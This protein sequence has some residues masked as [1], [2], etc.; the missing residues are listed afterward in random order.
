MPTPI[1]HLH[2]NPVGGI[3]GDMFIAAILDAFPQ[4]TDA[5]I[6]A[7]RA[8][9]LPNDWQVTCADHTDGRLTG[10]RLDIDQ[11][12]AGRQS[13]QSPARHTGNYADICQMLTSA[14]LDPA[15][16]GYALSILKHLA[17]AE[18]AVHGVPLD[19]VHFHEIA[20]WDSICDVV[21]AACLI[22]A[23]GEPTWS[24]DPL[25]RGGGT[26]DTAH[27]LLPA[28]APAT[29]KLLLGFAMFDDGVPGERVTPTG[30]AILR[31]LK[32]QPRLPSAPMTLVAEGTGF[33]HRTLPG[34]SNIL[35][36]MAFT[37]TLSESTN[38]RVGILSFEIDDQSPE[39]LALGLDNLRAQPHVYDVSQ[40]A[41]MGKKGRMVI[42]I[43]V[44]CAD[45]AVD[46]L[47]QACLSQTATLGVRQRFEARQILHREARE[48]DGLR[49][50]RAHRPGGHMTDKVEA[51]DL[52][53]TATDYAGRRATR[54]TAE[55]DGRE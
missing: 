25:P 20:D 22:T 5:V 54:S 40:F 15:V 47:T 8:A 17:Q 50:K 2:L 13:D 19:Q 33:G 32:P 42:Q 23:L 1:H 53:R 14:A 28:P 52:A 7:M 35:R 46:A 36:V 24:V 21:G 49:I 48:V 12:G 30:A 9:G 6:A 41:G 10:H 43:Q 11:P 26:I 45:H 34:M 3:A 29:A 55:N 4:H 18:S 37:A 51:D 16:R 39:D 27:G 38:S 44:I 31:A